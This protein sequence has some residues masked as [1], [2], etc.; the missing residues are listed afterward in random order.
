VSNRQFKLRGFRWLAGFQHLLVIFL[1]GWAFVG[2][3]EFE[4]DARDFDDVPRGEFGG[5]RDAAAVDA[6]NFGGRANH[7][8]VVFT[9]IDVRATLGP[10]QPRSFTVASSDFPITVS[11]PASM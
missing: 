2:V 1:G 7:I 10:N 5:M 8:R 11:L 6:G 3:A 4:A 9:A